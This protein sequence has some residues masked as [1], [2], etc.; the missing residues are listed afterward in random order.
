MARVTV[1]SAA[2]RL[3]AC[4]VVGAVVGF[5]LGIVLHPMLGISLGFSAGALSF[6]ISVW[7]QVLLMDGNATK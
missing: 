1:R 6:L 5:A 7:A 3:I 4:A 2:A